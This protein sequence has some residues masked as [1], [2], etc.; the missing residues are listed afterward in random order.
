MADLDGVKRKLPIDALAVQ[1]GIVFSSDNERQAKALCPF[2]DDHNP[3][4]LVDKIRGTARCFSGGCVAHKSMDHV[5][6]VRMVHHLSEE[7]AIDL[8]YEMA[9]EPRPIDSMSDYLRRVL[10]RC[11]PNVRMP[12]PSQFFL[13]RGVTSDTLDELGVGYSPSYNWFREAIADVPPDI[14]AKLELMQPHLFEN[15]IIYPQFDGRGKVAGFRI[16][17]FAGLQSYYSTGRDFPLRASRVYGL[18]L[19]RGKQIILVEGPNDVLALRSYGIRNAAGLNG[20]KTKDVEVF[21]QE[22]G[23]T[24]IVFIADGEEAGRGAILA[25]PP[26]IRVNQIP[27]FN[28]DPDEYV[29]KYGMV[30]FLS[31][32]NNAK[33]P[34]EMRLDSRLRTIPDSTTGKI[35]LA[36]SIARDI[37]E[38]LPQIVLHRV[39][40]RV[41]EAL[42]LPA[43]DVDL[44]FE[45]I[46]YDTDSV[47]A[48]IISHVALKGPMADDI[49]GK[50][51][52]WMFANPERR[53][54]YEELMQG[55]NLSE[56]VTDRGLL[57][58][59]DVERFIDVCRRRRLKSTLHQFASRIMNLALPADDVVSDAMTKMQDL[60]YQALEIVDSTVQME[61]IVRHANER[62]RNQDQSLGISLG[63]GFPKTNDLTLGFRE[64]AYYVLAGF[65]GAGKSMLALEWAVNI[66]Y[67]QGIPVLWVNLEMSAL[68]TYSRIAAK[69]TGIQSRRFLTGKFETEEDVMRAIT[70]PLGYKGRPLYIVK[71][72]AMTTGQLVALVRR[73]KMKHGIRLV[74]I[75]Y[76]GL[77]RSN[78]SINNS[79][80]RVGLISQ[81]LKNLI[82]ESKELGMPVL[83]LHQL[84][85][86]SAKLA[87]PGVDTM[88]DSMKVGM[89]ADIVATIKKR[90]PEEIKAD[91][92]GRDL[93]DILLNVAK[94]R[95]GEDAKIGLRFSKKSLRLWEVGV[96]EVTL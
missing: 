9:G 36:K 55:T 59:G 93:G 62:Y 85:R 74:V 11:R 34:F 31:L 77:I 37:T 60:S 6:L 3:S 94:N 14:A 26:M 64:S 92:P 49:K 71:P 65:T 91:V 18:H 1:L 50:V 48:R 69:L 75:D 8:L 10:D 19:V 58:D 56:H 72:G 38:G 28:V 73:M 15:S 41:A 22:R 2:H 33:F 24:D 81:D 79:Y 90:T 86:S 54:Q 25:A 46:D 43:P 87:A 35:M 57:T 44:I 83:A 80:E 52:P 23:F 89:D 47:E 20:N 61:T 12:V 67:R 96:Q 32:V 5:E 13:D 76:L 17:P 63:H 7:E 70:V 29:K 95:E 45:L 84:N 16:R 30:P 82:V 42:G 4:F 78:L 27:E 88:A 66:A 39:R 51:L 40:V 21:L 68:G 53:R